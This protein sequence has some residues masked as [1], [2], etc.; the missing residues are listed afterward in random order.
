MHLSRARKILA[1][2]LTA[3]L[4][5]L[6]LFFGAG[7]YYS[8][9][10]EERAFKVHRDPAPFDLRVTSIASGR[11]T[12][13]I[14]QEGTSR[15]RWRAPGIWG[16]ESRGTYNQVA[17]IIDASGPSLVREFIALGAPPREGDYVRI[18]REAYPQDPLVAHGIEFQDVAVPAALG[19]FP[20]WLT[21]GD[22]HTWV[23]FV[24]GQGADR[25]EFLRVLPLFVERGYPTLAITY[26]NDEGLPSNERRYYQ[27]GAEEWEELEAAATFALAAG[28]QDLIL[29]GYSMGGAI[30]ASFLHKSEL[31]VRARGVILDAPALDLGEITDFGGAQ[32]RVLGVPVPGPVTGLAKQLTS[33]RFG[34]D[35]DA[36]NH[37]QHAGRWSP[38]TEI[39][40]FHGSEDPTVPVSLSD[41]LAEARPD[42]VEYHRFEGATH[43]SSWNHD[44]ERYESAVRSFL[45]RLD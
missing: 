6:A 8:G 44:R 40:L 3:P 9:E 18:D 13:E 4:G 45:D 10:I 21:A 26:R 36:M 34:V 1:I 15:R 38:S 43:V 37:L 30:V 19:T 14:P 32:A 5:L 24:H 33:L 16:L 35:F 31:A 25:R 23:I 28:A 7:W 20:A 39:L 12:L 22:S 2:V 41:K 11:V 29:V 42:I 17:A 27:F